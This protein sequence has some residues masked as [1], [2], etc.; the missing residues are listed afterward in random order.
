MQGLISTIGRVKDGISKSSFSRRDLLK[1]IGVSSGAA[2][3][4]CA[5]DNS[6]KILPNIHGVED[7]IP[8]HAVWYRS[9][10]TECSAGCGLEIRTREGRAVKVEGN[11]NSPINGGGLCA[12]GQS[13]IQGLYD[14]DRVREPIINEQGVFKA[15]TYEKAI[16]LVGSALA[17]K[18]KK[19]FITGEKSGTAAELIREFTA[20]NGIEWVVYDALQPVHYANACEQVFGVKGIPHLDFQSAEVILN[21]GA[22]FLET[23]VS[24]VEF[25]RAWSKGRKSDT[26]TKLV[27]IEP[28]LSLT[29]GNADQWLK[30]KPG[31]DKAIALGILKLV[32]ERGKAGAGAEILK[33]ASK[34]VNELSLDEVSKISGVSREKLLS[35]ADSLVRAKKGSLVI[36]GH[37]ASYETQVVVQVLNLVLG[38]VGTTIDLG[39]VRTVNTS[40]EKLKNFIDTAN[41]GEVEALLVDDSNP[42]FTV[43]SNLGLQYA[44]KKVAMVAS[45]SPFL[46]ETSKVSNVVAPSNHSFESW[47]DS[48]PYDGV[49][50]LIQPAMT[51]L[52][53]TKE[54]GDMILDLWN[55]L[56]V[57]AVPG[58]VKTYKEFLTY[59]WQVLH[60]DLSVK[61][62]F[63]TFWNESLEKGGYFVAVRGGK[64]P[65]SNNKIWD[66]KLGF[67]TE[68]L[69]PEAKHALASE[70]K[71]V[72]G[73]SVHNNSVHNNEKAPVI[74][75]P[76]YSVKSFDGR[77]ANKPWMQELPDPITNVVWDTWAELHPDTAKANNL[78]QGDLV[79][80]RNIYGELNIPVYVTEFVSPGMIAIPVGQGHTGYGR[81]AEQVQGG[82]V[83]SLLGSLKSPLLQVSANLSRSLG[84]TKLTNTDGSRFQGG[85]GIARSERVT[86]LGVEQ[87][88]K[89]HHSEEHGEPKQMY[90][91]RIHPTY[92]WGM[93]I[94]LESCTGCA[95]CVVAC[96][97]ENNIPVVGKEIVHQ[98]REMSW[99]RIDR[100]FDGSAEELQVS[101]MPMMCQHCGNA[102]CEPVCP[103]YA[104]YHGEDG[105]NTMVYN[106][107]VGTRYCSNN[108]S[109]KVRRFNWFEY[110]W[111]EPLNMQL[112]PDVTVRSVGV[113]EKCTFCV[114]RIAEGKDK[115][116]S[117]GRLVRDG[118]I[119]T[120]CVQSCPTE[121]IIFGDL[122]DPNSNVS[123]LSK[124]LRSYRVLQEEINTQPAI[125]YLKDR[126]FEI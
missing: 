85:R 75:Y 54:F 57:A 43:P 89:P 36:A 20:A 70:S 106:R 21:F 97:A 71:E 79:T 101:F 77:A 90:E 55:G 111:P 121:A 112:N 109:Y 126:K 37:H 4:G 53:G 60:K 17:K 104:T 93:A 42:L 19:F 65:I 30:N 72:E 44:I 14:P 12:L 56:G 11:T 51:P 120:A 92:K 9:T 124:T 94:D 119:K 63:E 6:Q 13:G 28:R 2:L 98:G 73:H 110:Q 76:Y 86:S 102:P 115:A 7:Q 91:Q 69:D 49:Y 41:K 10:C 125:T 66:T 58:N 83:F 40:I 52:Y 45:F 29:G 67:T 80:V 3:T 8:G 34:W 113:M 64:L 39:R 32:L 15:A 31:T 99:L 33:N 38:N 103:V 123:K 82:N 88:A 46:D 1:V 107:C 84:K 116:K 87:S 35:V 48:K 16:T 50:S 5:D 59:N 108:C 27:H 96:Y 118:E 122:N 117:E 22:D 47:G 26:P 105:L 68:I 100:Y 18:G 25:A 23:W 114:Q 24:P 62:D 78:E 74:V 81:F 61:T 95:A